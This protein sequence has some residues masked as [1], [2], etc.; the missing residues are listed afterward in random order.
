MGNESFISKIGIP[1][2]RNLVKKWS[3]D[4]FNGIDLTKLG[5]PSVDYNNNNKQLENLIIEEENNELN[6]II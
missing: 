1:N 6:N 3:I 5:P 4:H 2:T